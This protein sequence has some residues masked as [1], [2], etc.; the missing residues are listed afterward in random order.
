MVDITHKNLS[1]LPRNQDGF[2]L[3]RHGLE[4]SAFGIQVGNFP[5]HFDQYPAHDESESGQEEVYAV[6]RGSGTLVA[7]SEE[8]ELKEH[9]FVRVGPSVHRSFRAGSNGLTLLTIGGVPGKAYVAPEW[10][11]RGA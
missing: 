11:A 5:P 2:V 9:D 1:E 10:T 3:A 7:D 6:L 8:H 4:V